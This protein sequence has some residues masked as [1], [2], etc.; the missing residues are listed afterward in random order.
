MCP[1]LLHEDSMKQKPD[2]V[3][4]ALFH[5]LRYELANFRNAKTK[6]RWDLDESETKAVEKWMVNRMEEIEKR[7]SK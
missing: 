4:L 5:A 6:M 7:L 3:E 2:G 1:L